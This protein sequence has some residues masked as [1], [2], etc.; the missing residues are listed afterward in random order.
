MIT[1]NLTAFTQAN[2]VPIGKETRTT[3]PELIVAARKLREAGTLLP[4]E[5]VRQQLSRKS[6]DVYPQRHKPGGYTAYSEV[7][8]HFFRDVRRDVGAPKMPFV[9]GV[10]GVGGT[11]ADADVVEF[12]KAMA[13]TAARP[14]FSGNVAFVE[15]RHFVRKPEDSPNP[16]HGHHEF[17]N[18]ETY[19][20]VGDALGMAMKKLAVRE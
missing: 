4:M 5:T 14:E 17:G 13:V 1:A 15:T 20:L 8:A 2:G 18:A 7:M 9:I 12:R 3:P 6:G 11:T 19:F 16:G 10:M